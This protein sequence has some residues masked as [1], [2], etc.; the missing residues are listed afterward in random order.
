MNERF[1]SIFVDDNGNIVPIFKI[2]SSTSDNNF[3]YKII[4]YGILKT[5]LVLQV[6]ILHKIQK[7]ILTLQLNFPTNLSLEKTKELTNR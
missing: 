4:L 7:I 5:V 6:I 2:R 1:L 3:P